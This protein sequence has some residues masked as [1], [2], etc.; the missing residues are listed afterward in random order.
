MNLNDGVYV[1]S[2]VEG[3]KIKFTAETGAARS[4]LSTKVFQRLEKERRPELRKS[5]NLRGAN[6]APIREIGKDDFKMLLG[7]CESVH[8]FVVADI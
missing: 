1:K 8:D 4:V 7:S 2:E 3:Q 5:C 6:G